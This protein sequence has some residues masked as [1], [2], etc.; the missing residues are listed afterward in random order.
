MRYK[1]NGNI[2]VYIMKMSNLAGKLKALD[3]EINEN[4]L[5]HLILISLPAQF[6][7]FKISYNTQK[8]KWSINELISQ[9]VQEE[10]RIKRE[11]IENVHLATNFHGKKKRKPTDAVE[12]T[13][14]QNKKQAMKNPCFFYKKK[15]HIKKNCPKYAKW[16]VKK[17]KLLTLVCSEVNLAY[18]PTDTWSFKAEVEL[19]LEKKIKVVKSDRG[20]EYCGRYDGSGKKPSIRHLHLWGC[21]AEARPYKPNERKLD[22]RTIN[23][24]FVGYYEH[25]RGFKFYDPTSKSFFETKNAKFLEDVEF[26]GE[27]N[28]KKVVFEEELVS[29]PNVVIDDVQIPI[30]EFTMK[31]I[32]KQDNNEVPEAQT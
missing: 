29:L 27:D 5:V 32:I 11:M 22:P 8:D 6:T 26:E 17:G 19:Q 18:V 14:Q 28:I 2:R 21:P 30:P 15:G 4:L 7:Q 3:I 1:G 13:S 31:P 12:G 25:S 16:R 9:C 10:Y 20:G 23:Y 24:Y